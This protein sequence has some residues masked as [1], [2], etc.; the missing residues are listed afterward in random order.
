MIASLIYA[1]T[2]AERRKSMGESGIK[3]TAMVK[4]VSGQLFTEIVGREPTPDEAERI[5]AAAAQR[6]P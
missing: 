6:V 4:N 3:A 5:A 1:A 2:W